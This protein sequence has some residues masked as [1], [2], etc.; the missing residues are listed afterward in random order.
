[1]CQLYHDSDALF[2]IMEVPSLSNIARDL[3][4]EDPDFNKI[5]RV[6]QFSN[7]IL[8]NSQTV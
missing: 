5:Y 6:R 8:R 3:L 2:A 1:M 7:C 4:R